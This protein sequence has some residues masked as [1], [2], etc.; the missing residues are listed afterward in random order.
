MPSAHDLPVGDFA[1]ELLAVPG[2]GWV[3]CDRKLADDDPR[4]VVAYIDCRG[5]EVS[6][7]WVRERRRDCSYATIGEALRG[8]SSSLDDKEERGGAPAEQ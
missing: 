4:R 1:T 8:M 2:D 5:G 3:V 6:V 7:T